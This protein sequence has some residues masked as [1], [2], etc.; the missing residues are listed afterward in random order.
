MRRRAGAE[1]APGQIFVVGERFAELEYG[2]LSELVEKAFEIAEIAGGSD[3]PIFS[4]ELSQGYGRRG[5]GPELV[6]LEAVLVRPAVCLAFPTCRSDHVPA[7]AL[8]RRKD[9]EQDRNFIPLR[10]PP[11]WSYPQAQAQS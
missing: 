2:R 4:R 8:S 10:N 5:R 7:P 9:N 11:T 3:C 1:P 6:L